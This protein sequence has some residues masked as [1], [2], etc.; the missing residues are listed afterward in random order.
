VVVLA[1][2]P[3]ARLPADSECLE[4]DQ[5]HEPAGRADEALRRDGESKNNK[6]QD[7]LKAINI[8]VIK[9]DPAAGYK[10]SMDRESES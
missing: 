6:D 2:S 5:V 3:S 7:E 10:H 9:A 1:L 8:R 4:A